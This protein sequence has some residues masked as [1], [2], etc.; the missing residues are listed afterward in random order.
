MWG[1][2][3]AACPIN[4]TIASKKINNNISRK[5]VMNKNGIQLNAKNTV[6]WGAI[7]IVLQMGIFY[8]IWMN[9]FVNE[10][11][12]KFANNPAVKPYEYFGGL[13]NW[14]T[15]RTIYNIFLLAIVFKVFLMFYNNIP[16]HGWKK[17]LNFG[18]IISLLSVIPA[19]FNK[20]TLIVYPG[21]LIVLQLVNGI[22]GVT[23][24]GVLAAVV[25]QKFCINNYNSQ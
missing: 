19:A 15:I 6:V 8:I 22:I 2:C 16:G 4:N 17:G 5:D 25:S 9:P 23:I 10:I 11:S 3:F 7:I 1:V 20:W 18:F 24:F 21:E 14:M 13:S 12:L